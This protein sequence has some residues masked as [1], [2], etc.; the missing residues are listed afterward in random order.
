MLL[1]NDTLIWRNLLHSC[2]QRRNLTSLTFLLAQH[3]FPSH[4]PSIPKQCHHPNLWSFTAF[5]P[6]HLFFRG[7][8]AR[9][10]EMHFPRAWIVWSWRWVLRAMSCAV[11]AL[12]A[13]SDRGTCVVLIN[14]SVCDCGMWTTLIK[15][16]LPRSKGGSVSISHSQTSQENHLL[17]FWNISLKLFSIPCFHIR[18]KDPDEGNDWRWEE[19]G[20]TEDE[21]VGWHHRL[22]GHEF[23]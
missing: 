2:Y 19:K 18:E 22:N 9:D 20:T 3:S 13:D 23:E 7:Y 15:Y 10:V 5:K 17:T 4:R 8:G 1:R 14:L 11:P 12:R 21:M 16:L 6:C